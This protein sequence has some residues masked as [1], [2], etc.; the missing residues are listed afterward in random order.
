MLKDTSSYPVNFLL[1]VKS[2]RQKRKKNNDKA[3]ATSDWK[4]IFRSV[5]LRRGYAIALLRTARKKEPS[6]AAAGEF[7]SPKMESRRSTTSGHRNKDVSCPSKIIVKIL[8]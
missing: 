5:S 8:H 7:P 6:L 3:T 2:L 4:V 1:F